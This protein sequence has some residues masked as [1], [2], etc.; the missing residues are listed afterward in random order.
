MENSVVQV[1]T[2]PQTLTVVF[3]ERPS[4]ITIELYETTAQNK[5]EELKEF[6]FSLVDT[7]KDLEIKLKGTNSVCFFVAQYA[8][9]MGNDNLS[10]IALD[11]L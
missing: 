8:N 3:G 4:I 9:S 11:N 6:I 10:W 2:L 1:S 5:K 7:V